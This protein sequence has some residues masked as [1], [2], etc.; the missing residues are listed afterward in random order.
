MRRARWGG[1]TFIPTPA[2]VSADSRIDADARRR[3]ALYFEGGARTYPEAHRPAGDV[4]RRR[5]GAAER[6]GFLLPAD[7]NM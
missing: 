4:H 5:A 2:S 3:A 1:N 6:F 7:A